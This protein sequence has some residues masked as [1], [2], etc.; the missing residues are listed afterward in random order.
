[1]MNAAQCL[2][3]I[4]VFKP[5]SK[6]IPLKSTLCALCKTLLQGHCN[7]KFDGQNDLGFF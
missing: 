1:M 2:L 4:F 5:S 6:T 3:M 7:K